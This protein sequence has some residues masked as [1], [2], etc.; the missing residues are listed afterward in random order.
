M[1]IIGITGGIGTGKSTVLKIL[2]DEHHAYVVE[3][4]RLAHKLMEPGECAYRE[5]VHAFGEGILDEE[6]FVN[7][8][9]L[10]QIVFSNPK[11]L[12][13]LNAIVHPRVK[14]AIIA[15]I[16][17]KCKEQEYDIY[18]IE[19]ALLIEDGYKEICD[20]I[21]FIYSST[22]VRVKRLINGRGGTKEKWIAVMNNQSSE[23][24][25]RLNCDA[26]IDNGKTIEDTKKAIAQLLN[27]T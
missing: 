13:Q 9:V 21:W 1:K 8:S 4:D 11:Q 5:L 23:Q 14:E 20:E 15:D 19:A 18:V 26:V 22:D 27:E 2:Q 6:G 12:Q 16:T 3:A 25:Y 7:R 17:I 10:G 24:Y